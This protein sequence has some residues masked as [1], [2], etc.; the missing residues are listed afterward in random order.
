MSGNTGFNARYTIFFKGVVMK[1]VT[2]KAVLIGIAL[3]V[4]VALVCLTGCGK[5]SGGGQASAGLDQVIELSFGHIQNPGH[6]LYVSTE[7]FKRV[8]EERS[9][10]RVKITIYPSSQLGSNRE[11]MEQCDMGT[12]DITFAGA[13]DWATVTQVQELA[14]YELPFLYKNLDAQK[15]LIYDILTPEIGKYVEKT[16]LRPLIINT[17]GMRNTLSRVKPINRLEDIKGMKVRMPETALYVD[18]WTALGATVV[19][20]PWSEAYTILQQGVADT[21]EPDTVGMVNANLHEIGKYYTR[22]G[23]MGAIYITFINKDKWNSIPPDLQQILR[24]AGRETAEA[25]INNRKAEDAVAEDV[26]AKA[27]VIAN[28]VAPAERARMREA[29]KPV[30]DNFAQKYNL[31]PLVDRLLD[32]AA[33]QE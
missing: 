9:N 6:S 25:Q 14:A 17:N 22:L 8:V 31:R 27:G 3:V 28:D 11:M 7:E 20:S 2:K 10:G 30:Y 24:D 21:V 16:N 19:T 1:A 5:K 33:K 15:S 18:T 12:L 4:G 23:Q 32:W 13:S 26:M 29:V